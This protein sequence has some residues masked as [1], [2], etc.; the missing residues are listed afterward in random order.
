MYAM[1]F[2]HVMLSLYFGVVVGI[3]VIL[4]WHNISRLVL[5]RR[6]RRGQA[7]QQKG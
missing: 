1:N 7:G 6:E 4:S 3:T 5:E 2:E